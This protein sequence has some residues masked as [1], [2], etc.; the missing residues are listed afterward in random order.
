MNMSFK[1]VMRN[2][3]ES[4]RTELSKEVISHRVASLYH[5]LD[6]G[7]EIDAQRKELLKVPGK[8]DKNNAQNFFRYVERT[9]VEAKATMMDLLPAVL[10]AM[11]AKRACDML[12][13]FLNPIGFS[14]TAIGASDVNAC[15]DQLLHN[16]NKETSEAF[17]AVISLGENAT[18]DQIR[19]AY[20]EV[21][22]AKNSHTPM[23]EYLETLM[24]KKAA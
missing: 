7:H 1:G 11:P 22:E 6:L 13:Q 19:D 9:S 20:R 21:Q 14:V 15:R 3:I 16:H 17:R 8:D 10:R 24:N 12:N 4:W 2:A 5:K 18:I 23:L